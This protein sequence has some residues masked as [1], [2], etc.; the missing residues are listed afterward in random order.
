MTRVVIV[1]IAGWALIAATQVAR[2]EGR[3]YAGNATEV[4]RPEGRA[5]AQQPQCLHGAN[6]PPEQ[7][8]RRRDALHATRTVNNLEANQPGAA[9][10]LYLRQAELPSSPFMQRTSDAFMKALD[11][12]PGHDLLSGWTLTLET[13]E[14]GYWF[15][16]KDKTD[17]CGFAYISNTSGLIYSAEPIR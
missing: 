3:A 6:E 1:S 11:F 16:I 7:S 12:T 17:P 5:Y 9:N 15:M 13:S 10:S 2:P 4:A 8:A 14:N